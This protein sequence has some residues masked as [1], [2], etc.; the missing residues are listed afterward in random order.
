MKD[1]K[2]VTP[3]QWNKSFDNM[4]LSGIVAEQDR[5]K[6]FKVAI[7]KGAI[8]EGRGAYSE[9]QQHFNTKFQEFAKATLKEI[10][11]L[12]L[13]GFNGSDLLNLKGDVVKVALNHK[14]EKK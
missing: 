10:K 5:S 7:S 6:M 14:T 1:L 9:A 13:D 8:K 11:E 4:V 12:K 3:N 2:Q